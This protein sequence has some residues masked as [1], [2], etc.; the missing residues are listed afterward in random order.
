MKFVADAKIPFLKGVLESAG[1]DVSYIDGAK[2]ARADLMDAEG[3][4]V[5]TR[6]ECN[7]ALLDGTKVRFIATATIGFDHIDTAYCAKK[8]IFWTNAPG[9]NSSSV[10]Q[11]ICSALMNWAVIKGKPLENL[12]IG[13][14]GVGNVGSKVAKVAETLGMKTLLN[15]P[16]REREWGRRGNGESGVNPF[17]PLNRIKDEAD[18]I[19]L[20][21][22]LDKEG[23]DRTFHLADGNFFREIRRRPLFINSS[24]GEVVDTG[25]LKNAIKKGLLSDAVIDVWENEPGIDLELLSLAKF[26]TPHIAGYSTDGKANGT[27]MSVRAASRFFRL[28]LDNWFPDGIP[29][30]ERTSRRPGGDG[31]SALADA[32]NFSYDIRKDDAAL[33][34][35]PGNFEALRGAYPLRREFPAFRIEAERLDPRTRTQL[36]GLG[37][38]I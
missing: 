38:K 19:S 28:G 12:K 17:V 36:Q 22:P 9:C 33:R 30:P 35:S 37:F 10:A 24:R 32:V 29:L 11:Y 8:G 5:R 1:A 2:I 21:V 27:A 14:V 15:D 20:H 31:L 6:T 13:I 7:A 23:P 25:A 34:M 16:P 3:L 26:A 4:V 18:I